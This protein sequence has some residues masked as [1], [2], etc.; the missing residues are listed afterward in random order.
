MKIETQRY[1][2]QLN[3]W[4]STG[5]HILAQHDDETIV[6]YQA[7]RSS[8]GKYAVENQHFGGDFSYSRMS[9][10]KTNFLWMMFRSGWGTK[11]DQEF[12][13]A[14]RLKRSFFE[15]MLEVAVG[16]TF[17]ASRFGSIEQ[18]KAAIGHSDVR[19][20]WDP[21]HDPSGARLERRAVQ[22][23][24]RGDALVEYGNAS[25][26]EI[27]D[28][29]AFVALQR[30]AVT[31]SFSELMTPRERVFSPYSVRARQNPWLSIA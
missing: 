22:L 2:E 26:V 3:H 20:Q 6:V 25:V 27:I 5:R 14:I 9:W 8:I 29:S 18:W 21:D 11:G 15:R 28:L 24:L 23:G 10:I 31:G 12:T 4:P 19:L 13:L 7:Y 16:S 30:G 1:I 17:D